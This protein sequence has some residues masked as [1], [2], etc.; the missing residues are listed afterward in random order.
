MKTTEYLMA[1]ELCAFE[2][3]KKISFSPV[4]PGA[5]NIIMLYNGVPFG[6]FKLLPYSNGDVYFYEFEIAVEYRNQG[7]GT[8]VFPTILNYCFD[9]GFKTIRLQV[10]SANPAALAIYSKYE[11][12]VIE[13][14]ESE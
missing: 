1:R 10:S 2:P 3:D 6:S 7:I 11:F 13:S 9:R 12:E 8:A 5:D 4:M 14:V